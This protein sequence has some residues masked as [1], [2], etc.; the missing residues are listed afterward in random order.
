MIQQEWVTAPAVLQE[1][2]PLIFQPLTSPFDFL[3]VENE[4]LFPFILTQKDLLEK[5][6]MLLYV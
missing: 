1:T 4:I 6:F 2:Q 5:V 3:T